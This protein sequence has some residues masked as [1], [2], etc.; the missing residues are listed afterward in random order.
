MIEKNPT[1]VRKMFNRIARRYDLA[2]DILSFGIHRLW[3]KKAVKVAK[4][5]PN[6]YILD[7]ATG[8]G[9]LAFEFAKL[10]NGLKIFALD[11]SENMIA[12]A[13]QKAK[14]LKLDVEFIIG[15]ALNIPFS[16]S[17]FDIVS[18]SYGIRNV[19]SI[20]K[21]LSE[22][23]RVLKPKGKFVIIEFGNPVWFFRPIYRILQKLFL[24]PLAGM[25]T[26]EKNAYKYLFETIRYF[27][28][29]SNFLEIVKKEDLFDNIR[30]IPL[31]FGIAYL[32]IAQVKK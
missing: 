1:I 13:Q 22:I 27:P 18:M 5:S 14:S 3:L 16:D 26:G 30:F 9:K 20:E 19:A 6:S 28:S 7:L 25:I 17:S 11:F 8:T 21:C 24:I 4:P 29:G 31:T 32:Y 23:A 10:K 12:I 2:N 15:D